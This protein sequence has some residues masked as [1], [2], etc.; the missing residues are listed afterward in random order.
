MK[1][2][3]RSFPLAALM[4]AAWLASPVAKGEAPASAP[5]LR[6]PR[7]IR[8]AN[9]RQLTFSG[10][11]AEAYFSFAGDRLIY[12]SREGKADCDQIYTMDLSGGSRRLVSTGKGRCTCAYFLKGDGRVVFSSTHASA[13]ECPA[14]PDLSRGYV[15]P[16]H[17]GYDVYEAAADGTDLKPL[18]A[19]P[20]YD[21]EATVSP[22][23]SKIVFTSDRDGDLELYLLDLSTR[24]TTRLTH[25]PGYD[26]GAFFSPDSQKI[27]FRGWHPTDPK[28]LE[29]YRSLLRD[30]L[31]RPSH[32]EIF[33]IRADGSGLRQVTS[34]GAANFCPFWHPDGKRI[35]FASNVGDE[36]KRNFDLYLVNEDGSGLEQVT[37]EPSFDG[38]PMFS[39]DGRHLVWGAN[40]NAA[41]PG[42]TNIFVAEWVEAPAGEAAF[43]EEALRRDVSFLASPDLRGR[44]TG[45]PE[46]REAAEYVAASFRSAGLRPPPGREGYLDAF[47][48]TSGVHLGEG[49]AAS[50]LGGGRV[51]PLSVGEEIQPLGMSE[52]GDLEALPVVFAG[53]GIRAQDQKWNDYDGLD[54]K[55]KAVVVYRWG[56]EGDD[57]KSPYALYYPIRHKAMTAR[58]MGAKALIVLGPSAQDDDLV[59]LSTTARGGSAG[60]VVLTA[61]RAPFAS[62]FEAAGLSLPDPGNPHGTPLRFE[63]PGVAF[64]AAVRLKREKAEGLNVLGWLPATRATDETVILGAHYDHLGLGVE[65]S[66]AEKKGEVHPGA[67][68]NASGTAGLMALARRFAAEPVRGRNLLFVSFAGEELGTLGSSQVVKAPPVPL[69]KAVAMLNF[70]MI[71]RLREN[72]LVV[73]GAGTSPVWKD[74]LA[75]ANTEGLSLSLGEDG[76]GASDHSVFYAQGIPVLFF[77]TGAHEDYH[78]PGDTADK[79][80]YGGEA[81]VLRLAA[82]V[83]GALLDLPERPAYVR[84]APPPS[85]MAGRGFRVYLGTIPDYTGEVKGVRLMGV[86]AGSPAEQGGLR[87]GDVIVGFAGKTIENVYDYT[88]ALQDHKPGETVAVTVLRDGNRVDLTVLLGR[89][90]G[91]D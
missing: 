54:V 59:P 71:G 86:R 74:L 39:P 29:E 77:F 78:R 38:F 17:P 9:V 3:V 90:P 49:N 70:D 68:D 88:Y 19:S 45:T 72:S 75:R 61:R 11:N 43:S 60:L 30:H 89:R 51:R 6:D 91:K 64:S 25:L 62:A 41:R 13:P 57:P 8:L 35:L 84:V 18:I 63:V 73:G 65:G 67:D 15:W 32:M 69:E 36:K 34:N 87:K 22:D 40:R 24:S 33:T 20:G 46:A 31:V 47:P 56:P 79:V 4:A 76:Y 50:L 55:G 48:F 53:Y 28:E 23:G 81:K 16:V 44:L 52:D 5:S 21:A 83:T 12:Q 27:V 10:E 85:E 26:G 2:A 7:E 80:L 82:R 58:E 37:F 66:L 1:T 14:P 42:E